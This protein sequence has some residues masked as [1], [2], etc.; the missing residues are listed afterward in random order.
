MS[1]ITIQ[2]SH[3]S[4]AFGKDSS[5]IEVLK[6]IN[7]TTYENELIMIMGPSGSGKSTLIS[8][9]AGILHQDSG[10]CLL[11]D[12]SINDLVGEEKTR[13]RAKHIG[14][15]FQT[16]NLIP[17]LT[18][19]QNAA[20]PLLLMGISSDEAFA[21]SEELLLRFGLDQQRYRFPSSLSGGEQQRVAI[22]RGCIHKPKILLCDEPTSFLDSQRGK[23]VIEILREIK[24]TQN[25]TLI[26]VTHDPRILE[27]ADTII[28]IQDGAIR[29]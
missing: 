21:K 1:N 18:A 4:K 9:I 10:E 3:V 7:L 11:L 17:T 22:A 20:M 12:V 8:I 24:T 5:R 19:V 15:I 29:K 28:Y 26:I 13:F 2:C 25:S 14:F 16:F 6:D 23:A 27:F